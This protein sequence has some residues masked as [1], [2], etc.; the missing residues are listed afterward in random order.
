MLATLIIGSLSVILA[1][2]FTTVLD[3]ILYAY[4]FMVS[5]LFIPTLGAYFWKRGTSAGA[6]AGMLGGGILTLLL[7]TETFV[8]P[9]TLT[10]W[11][12]DFSVYGITLS[13]I[14]Y[15]LVSL[16]T[17]NEISTSATEND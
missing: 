15:I 17:K 1:A 16:F 11:E 5:G 9:D 14:L 8:L 3:A 7:M 12:L 13:A 10:G 4:S 2:S 6:I